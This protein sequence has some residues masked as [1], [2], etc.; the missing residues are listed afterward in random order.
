MLELAW[1][2]RS[3]Q[4]LRRLVDFEMTPTA[5]WKP[6]NA[7]DDFTEAFAATIRPAGLEL[8][9]CVPGFSSKPLTHG[10]S[11]VFEMAEYSAKGGKPGLAPAD[12]W[13]WKL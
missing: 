13:K 12:N 11:Q 4:P 2:R 5:S 6:G 7:T 8:T 10:V 3:E 9:L 1:A